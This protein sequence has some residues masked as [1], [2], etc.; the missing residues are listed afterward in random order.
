MFGGELGSGMPYRKF[1]LYNIYIFLLGCYG[2]VAH[3]MLGLYK[4]VSIKITFI[5]CL[6]EILRSLKEN[7]RVYFKEGNDG[8][9]NNQ[10]GTRWT[11]QWN[12]WMSLYLWRSGRHSC[13]GNLSVVL[14]V[15]CIVFWNILKKASTPSFH[16]N[17]AAMTTSSEPLWWRN[18]I[19]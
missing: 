8:G 5:F 7:I 2:M 9:Y 11:H 4:L 18:E 19:R 16:W 15:A 17:T 10:K 6:Y 14:S 12:W 13:G 3:V 1:S